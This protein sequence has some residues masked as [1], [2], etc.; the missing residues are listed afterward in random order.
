MMAKSRCL[1][2]SR[3]HLQFQDARL[4]FPTLVLLR[5]HRAD[6]QRPGLVG[7]AV[8]SSTESVLAA[9]MAV[10]GPMPDLCQIT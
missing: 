6:L 1:S 9:Q 10:F 7:V 2:E 4:R 8:G 3:K 5:R